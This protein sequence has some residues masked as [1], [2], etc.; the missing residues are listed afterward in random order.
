[1]PAEQ[2]ARRCRRSVAGIEFVTR[3]MQELNWS[4]FYL[5][6]RIEEIKLL[7]LVFNGKKYIPQTILCFQQ[8]R[9]FHKKK[10]KN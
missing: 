10:K 4:P 5:Q 6:S 3:I 9:L 2:Q 7:Y 1:M 8:I